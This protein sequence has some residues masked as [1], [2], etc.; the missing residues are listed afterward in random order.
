MSTHLWAGGESPAYS[1]GVTFATW[2]S[3]VGSAAREN[4]ARRFSLVVVDEAHHAPAPAYRSLI[5]SLDPNFLIGLTA[6][7]WRGDERNLSD[8][9]EEPAFSMDIVAGMQDGYLADVDYR[10]LVDDVDWE[11]IQQ[12]SHEGFSIR[13]LNQRLILP[14][15][16]EA[17]VARVIDRMNHLKSPRV[18]CF[19]RSIEHAER[20]RKLFLAHNVQAECAP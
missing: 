20:A 15:R 4:L 2:Q 17:M 5:S 1:G 11:E 13:D 10:M 19:C 6:T 16:D 12:L 3:V 14:D 9:F 8:I 7:P 18:M